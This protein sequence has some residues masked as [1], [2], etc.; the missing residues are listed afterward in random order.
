[1]KKYILVLLVGLA[2][3]GC[4][5]PKPAKIA[6]EERQKILD[7]MK[8]DIAGLP[9]TTRQLEVEGA[10]YLKAHKKLNA[11][12]LQKMLDKQLPPFPKSSFPHGRQMDL[13]KFSDEDRKQVEALDAS[14]K[15]LE[16]SRPVIDQR[17]RQVEWLRT[18]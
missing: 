2:L 13:S 17:Q 6:I 16:T 10:R 9:E 5:D 4:Y 18:H 8:Q 1:M 15:E 3:A 7:K 12:S 11:K 14:I